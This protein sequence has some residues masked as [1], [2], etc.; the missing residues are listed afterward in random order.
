MF[1]EEDSLAS[2]IAI[3]D[4]NPEA[5]GIKMAKDHGIP[6]YA[7]AGE[8]LQACRSYPD[9]IVYNL[10]HDDAIGELVAKVFANKR[11]ASE[12]EAKLF[13]QTVNNLQRVKK[14]LEKNQSQ[15]QA[16]IHNAMDG[17]ITINQSGEIQGFNPAAEKMF[18][19]LQQDVLGK[20][21]KMLMPEPTRSEHNTYINRY[22]HTGHGSLIGVRGREV[23]AI[24]KN[25]ELFPMELSASD[26]I[27]GGQRYFVGIVRDITDRKLAESKITFLAHHDYLTGLPNR[28]LFLERLEQAISL[29]KR[30]YHKVAILYLDLDGFKKVND[31]FG[32][33]VGDLLLQD[34]AK[35]LTGIIRSSDTVARLGGDEFAIILINIGDQ[36]YASMVANKII[37][38]LSEPF[39]LKGQRCQ[40]GG[41]IGIAIFP[42][43]A[44]E[45]AALLKHAD[46]AMYLSKHRGKNTYTFYSEVPRG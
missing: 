35:R 17:I 28:A 7:D 19:Y 4:P 37:D 15:L 13:W 39:D 33:D 18:G 11:V 44:E 31:A 21:V 36:K 41:S 14:E 5:P 9:C 8:A 6:T 10:T 27:L 23:T 12:I 2:V 22:L 42:D 3:V 1:M 30:N 32:H 43:D 40:V 45:Y 34:V 16:V 25:G 24:R 29:A 20:N 26:M 38:G 46:Q